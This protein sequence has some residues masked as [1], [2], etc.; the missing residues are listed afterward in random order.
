MV[1]PKLV[2][3]NR[4]F[5]HVSRNQTRPQ[6]LGIVLCLGHTKKPL[7]GLHLFITN[8]PLAVYTWRGM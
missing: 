8:W 4:R 5:E 1:K 3:W 6:W 2:P 7:A